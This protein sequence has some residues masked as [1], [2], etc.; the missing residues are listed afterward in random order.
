VGFVADS[1]PRWV[2]LFDALGRAV[3]Q[4]DLPAPATSLTLKLAS[5][6][7]GYYLLRCGTSTGRLQVD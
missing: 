1:V 7:K 2:Q 4:Q 6:P 3:S 5:L